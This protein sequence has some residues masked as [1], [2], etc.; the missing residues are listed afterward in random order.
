[1]P[2]VIN[3]SMAKKKLKRGQKVDPFRRGSVCVEC[4]YVAGLNFVRV[5]CVNNLGGLR[6]VRGG[7]HDGETC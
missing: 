3:A 6:G 2:S 7:D 5:V 1:M 4:A